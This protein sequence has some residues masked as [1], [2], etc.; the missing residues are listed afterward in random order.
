MS[1]SVS[2]TVCEGYT[3]SLCFG[4]YDTDEP[5]GVDYL[6]ASQYLWIVLYWLDRIIK[7]TDIRFPCLLVFHAQCQHKRLLPCASRTTEI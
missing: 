4:V 1:V 6:I 3:R 2:L 7:G 5:A